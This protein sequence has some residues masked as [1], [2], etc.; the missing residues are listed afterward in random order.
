V[1]KIILSR[2]DVCVVAAVVVPPAV[3]VLLRRGES[4]YRRQ[5][6]REP[7]PQVRL[8]P[9]QVL[10]LGRH[11]RAA[12]STRLAVRTAEE[13]LQALEHEGGE[14]RCLFLLLLPGRVWV[15]RLCF[16]LQGRRCL[17]RRS[18]LPP[19]VLPAVAELH[20]SLPPGLQ[21]VGHRPVLLHGQPLLRP[22]GR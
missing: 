11:R 13:L 19:P 21:D 1:K 15:G 17:L 14:A 6:L 7:G 4:L 22:T 5:R 20:L 3:L 12:L 18:L 9:L 2:D 10:Q 16:C 8:L